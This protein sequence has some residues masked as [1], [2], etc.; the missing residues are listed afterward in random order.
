MEDQRE[1]MAYNDDHWANFSEEKR[2]LKENLLN[3]WKLIFHRCRR[4]RIEFRRLEIT[5]RTGT[6][7][8]QEASEVCFECGKVLHTAYIP[9][10]EQN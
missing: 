4:T 8:Y 1:P 3:L 6:R 7:V 10:E 2:N 5:N 9:E